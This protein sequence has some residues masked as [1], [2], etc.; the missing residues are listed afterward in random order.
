MLNFL[1]HMHGLLNPTTFALK[2][3]SDP[4]LTTHDSFA[5]SIPSMHQ[6]PPSFFPLQIDPTIFARVYNIIIRENPH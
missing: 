1:I 3:Q 5:S 6:Q 2:S 4:N